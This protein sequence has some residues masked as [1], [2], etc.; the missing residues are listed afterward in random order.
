VHAKNQDAL[1]N[2]VNA[3]KPISFV[4][5]IANAVTAKIMMAL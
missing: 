5:K 2:T 4:V 3:S 1:K